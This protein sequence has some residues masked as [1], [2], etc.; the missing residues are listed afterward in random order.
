LLALTLALE[1]WATLSW[2]WPG[3]SIGPV[4]SGPGPTLAYIEKNTLYTKKTE[5]T[6]ICN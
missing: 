5:I 6:K 3:A 1:V 4:Q 2:P